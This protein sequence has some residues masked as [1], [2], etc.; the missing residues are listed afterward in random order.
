MLALRRALLVI[1]VL[2][3]PVVLTGLLYWGSLALLAATNRVIEPGTIHLTAAIAFAAFFF[4][5]ILEARSR[6]SA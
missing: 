3:A 2:V 6:W 1:F 5:A 4:V